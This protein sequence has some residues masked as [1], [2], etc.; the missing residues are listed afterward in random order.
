MPLPEYSKR[1]I[2]GASKRFREYVGTVIR[3]GGNRAKYT[4][5]DMADYLD[6]NV[7][8]ID[9]YEH[10][11]IDITASLMATFSVLLDFPMRQYTEAYQEKSAEADILFKHLVRNSRKP[12]KPEGLTVEYDYMIGSSK[13]PRPGLFFNDVTGEWEMVHR[14]PKYTSSSK[15]KPAP[16]TANDDVMF[17]NYMNAE[18]NAG[19]LDMLQKT[20]SL[21]NEET[22][23]GEKECPDCLKK[24]ARAV[25]DYIA[26]DQNKTVQRRIKRYQKAVEA[27]YDRQD[28]DDGWRYV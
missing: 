22:Q 5:N 10:G 3:A 27:M 20:A 1:K 7:S 18:K 9:R 25:I 4:M 13:P 6:C 28:K 14:E 15:K 21:V 12:K 2:T 8:T 16:P 19:K 17:R 26:Y 23:H 11:E 24:L